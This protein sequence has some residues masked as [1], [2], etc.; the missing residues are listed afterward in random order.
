MT[1]TNKQYIEGAVVHVLTENKRPLTA[2]ELQK[3]LRKW[4]LWEVLS[5]IYRLE[6]KHRIV[7]I[8]VGNR[9]TFMLNGPLE[10]LAAL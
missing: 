9:S 4:E 10:R 3:C 7:R 5:A 6:D 1:Q 2:G 8:E